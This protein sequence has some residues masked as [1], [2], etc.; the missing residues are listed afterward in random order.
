MTNHL[1]V[2]AG[3][4]DDPVPI[5]GQVEIRDDATPARVA[6]VTSGYYCDEC[7]DAYRFLVAEYQAGRPGIA[8]RTPITKQLVEE[9]SRRR[10][11]PTAR[12]H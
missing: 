1:I 12:H 9:A 7:G 8:H 2:C 6:D 11:E 5:L 4:H 3:E 10:S